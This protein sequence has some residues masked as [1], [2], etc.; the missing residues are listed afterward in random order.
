ME[1]ELEHLTECP[2]CDSPRIR[3]DDAIRAHR[4][5][6]CGMAFGNP[7]LSDSAQV[8]YYA[9]AYRDGMNNWL[10]DVQRQRERARFQYARV[11]SHL[12]DVRTML[13]I[14]C[15]L[16]FLM[17]QFNIYQ[18]TECVGIEPELRNHNFDPARDYKY[19][20]D[21]SELP[22]R[23]FDLIAMSHSLEHM[24]HPRQ[25]L[26]SLALYYA[27]E[28]TRFMIEVPNIDALPTTITLNHPMGFTKDTLNNLMA[29]IG[30]IPVYFKKHALGTDKEFYLL[31]VY[32]RA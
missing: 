31:G 14:G 6:D 26:Q 4:C 25:Y 23:K 15:S 2:I 21:I 16:G 28:N 10:P 32:K 13:E 9:G 19:Y 24:N 29:R 17:D 7:R 5:D 8:E 3:R 1:Y 11:E 22:P 30:F 12:Q 18:D 27:H 20:A